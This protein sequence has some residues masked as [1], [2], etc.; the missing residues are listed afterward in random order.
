MVGRDGI[1]EGVSEEREC[2]RVCDRLSWG[3]EMG[4]HASGRIVS[5]EPT[6]HATF[7]SLKDV[8]LRAA[9]AVDGLVVISHYRDPHRPPSHLRL[10][11]HDSTSLLSPPCPPLPHSQ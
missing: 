7:K 6:W 5:S 2:V 11:S 3:E 8:R 9:E 10:I 4:P 1:R